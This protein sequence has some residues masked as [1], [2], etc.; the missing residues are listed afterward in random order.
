[1]DE[2]E[3]IGDGIIL[4][5]LWRYKQTQ[6]EAS[7]AKKGWK[8]GEL[9]PTIKGTTS[10]PIHFKKNLILYRFVA[11]PFELTWIGLIWGL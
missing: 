8:K 6:W 7:N 4:G 10:Q 5:I 3:S 1:M 9:L 11:Y 2:V